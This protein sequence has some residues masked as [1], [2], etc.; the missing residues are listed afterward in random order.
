[1]SHAAAWLIQLLPCCRSHQSASARAGTCNNSLLPQDSARWVREQQRAFGTRRQTGPLTPDTLLLQAPMGVLWPRYAIK[2]QQAGCCSPGAHDAGCCQ[3]LAETPTPLALFTHGWGALS[4]CRQGVFHPNCLMPC[5]SLAH[6]PLLARASTPGAVAGKGGILG[7]FRRFELMLSLLL[8]F[9]I[10]CRCRALRVCV[11][12]SAACQSAWQ[13]VPPAQWHS[14]QQH[15]QQHP[16]VA[17][18]VAPG[19]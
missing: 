6:E 10:C 7:I 4:L 2:Q 16:T 17:G 5:Q 11:P 14:S 15:Q 13:P 12:S 1:V 3:P 8:L 19:S 18:V 9:L